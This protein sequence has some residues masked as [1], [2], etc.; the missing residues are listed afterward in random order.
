MLVVKDAMVLI[1]LAKLTLLETTCRYFGA[2]AIPTKIKSE[3]VDTGQEHGYPDATVIR[4]VL[5]DGHIDVC[6]VTE[7]ALVERANE[8]N[9]QGGEA[10]ALAL[11]WERN[12]DLLATDDDNVRK[13]ETLLD[14]DVIGTP[15]ILLELFDVEEIGIEKL[16]TAVEQL[17]TIGWFSTAVLD[18]I[19]LEAGL[20]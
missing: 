2:V 6:D 9:I 5:E 19:E 10:H 18:T 4:E 17:R 13:K 3:T 14:I 15:A 16:Q 20:T 8:Y 12:A 11:Y 7:S 1:H